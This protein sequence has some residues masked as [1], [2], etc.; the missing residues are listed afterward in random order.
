MDF[1]PPFLLE[2]WRLLWFC[3]MLKPFQNSYKDLTPYIIIIFFYLKIFLNFLLFLFSVLSFD[4]IC[5]V[6]YKVYLKH[7]YIQLFFG[8]LVFKQMC[9]DK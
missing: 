5:K 6:Y 1:P 7:V 4:R 8:Y 3:G 9:K 2:E